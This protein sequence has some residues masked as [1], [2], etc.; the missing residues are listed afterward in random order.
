MIVFSLILAINRKRSKNVNKFWK[1]KLSLA[2]LTIARIAWK[3][4]AIFWNFRAELSAA[5]LVIRKA[6]Y[7]P[8]YHIAVMF[9]GFQGALK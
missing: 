8:R 1:K 5:D 2:I 6:P 4:E 3:N 9:E 7:S